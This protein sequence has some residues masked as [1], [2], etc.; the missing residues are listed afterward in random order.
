MPHCCSYHYI[1]Q[2]QL[3]DVMRELQGSHVAA[4]YIVMVTASLLSSQGSFIACAGLVYVQDW[5]ESSAET[6][7]GLIVMP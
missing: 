3:G 1:V 5:T 7:M 2:Q 6:L 4:L